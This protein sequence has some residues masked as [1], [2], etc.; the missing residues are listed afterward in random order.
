MTFSASQTA[1]VEW[2][3]DLES[4]TG[5][6]REASGHVLILDSIAEFY[7]K[8]KGATK[9]FRAKTEAATASM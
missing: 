8:T 5:K 1:G 4:I 9:S 2:W 6:D 7:G 3:D